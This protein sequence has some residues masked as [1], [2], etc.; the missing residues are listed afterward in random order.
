MSDFKFIDLFAGIGGFH[1]AME[2]LGGECIFASEIDLFA[3]KTYE[4]NFKK[5]NPTLFNEGMFNDDIRKINP[6]DL[7]DFDVLCAGFPCQPFSQAGHKRGFNDTHKSE[8]GNLFFNIVEILEVKKPKA[9]FLENVRGIVNHDNSN[10]FKVIRD[11][12]EDELGYSFHYQ[13]VKASDYGLPQLRPRTFMIGF[14]NEGVL[15]NFS[16]PSKIPLKFNMSDVWEGD[17]SREIGFTLRVGGRGSNINDRR[18]WDSYLVDGEV[19]KI[20]PEQ[21]RK[22]QGFPDTFEFPVANTQAMKQLGNSVAIDAIRACGEVMI[23]HLKTLTN[24]GINME[25]SKNKGEWT[26]LYSFLKLINDKKLILADKDLNIQNGFDHFN[27]TKVTTLNIMESCYLQDNDVVL[28]KNATTGFENKIKVS[29][30]LNTNILKK[31]SNS[32]KNGSRTFNIPEFNLIQN[33]LGISIVKGGNSNQKADIVLDIN[34]NKISKENEG[35]GIKSYLG[36]KPTLLNASGNTNFIFEI[37]NFEPSAIDAVNSIDTRTKLKDRIEKIHTLGG[38]FRFSKIETE[39]MEYNLSMVDSLIPKIMSTMLLEFYLN[40]TN[41]ISSNLENIFNNADTFGTDLISLQVK[42]KRLLVAILLGFFAGKKWDGNYV[43]NG[44][45]VVK[46]TGEQV[47]FHI[48]DKASLE[49][50][51]FENIKFDTPSTTRHRFGS[52]ILENNGKVYFKLN[53]QLR[54]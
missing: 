43:S 16:F 6:I 39:S 30:F 4:H 11:I 50:Y 36:S 45:I 51:L 44:T 5:S 49:N 7:P 32:I 46:E 47:G 23:T 25:S 1:I 35:F 26:E 2:S 42:V 14:K 15:S 54:F 53:M 3:R 34:N 8:R 33:R 20:M 38:A 52:L 28:V 9:F 48:I 13:V 18:N 19:K 27:V 31:L 41:G 37:L 10:T 12:I 29:D 24:M 22:M 40:R 17:C 21:A